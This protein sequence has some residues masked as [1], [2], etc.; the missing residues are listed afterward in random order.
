MSVL[1]VG[2]FGGSQSDTMI[3]A[4][5]STTGT[6]I[7]KEH[8]ALVWDV[9]YNGKPLRGEIDT[10]PQDEVRAGKVKAKETKKKEYADRGK[11]VKL[12]QKFL[13]EYQGHPGIDPE[14]KKL[15]VDNNEISFEEF[16]SRTM[17]LSKKSGSNPEPKEEKKTVTFG[18]KAAEMDSRKVAMEMFKE[19]YG[20]KVII[21]KYNGKAVAAFGGSEITADEFRVQMREAKAKEDADARQAGAAK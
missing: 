4:D 16:K 5:W 13:T 12:A 7:Q 3:T 1:V 14:L 19:L 15:Y 9:E 21:N 18:K 2:N 8:S 10:T 20:G 11:R 17:N 6:E